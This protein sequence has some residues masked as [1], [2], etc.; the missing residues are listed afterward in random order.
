VL[1]NIGALIAM[2]TVQLARGEREPARAAATQ[3]EQ[4][5]RRRRDRAGLAEA[6]ELAVRAAPEPLAERDRLSETIALWRDL[7]NSLGV[8]KAELALAEL[9]VPAEA[10]QLAE[11]ALRR[12]Q[13]LGARRAASAATALI[14]SLARIQPS[15]IEFRTLG[16]FE[17]LRHGRPV[18][19]AEWRSRKARDALK[20]LIASRGRRLARDALMETLW[21]EEDPGRSA[22]RLSVALS[23]I[24]SVLDQDKENAAD[25]YL[26]TDRGSVW[27]ALDHLSV[28]LE[29]FHA[30]ARL[31]LELADE[32]QVDRALGALQAAEAAYHGDFLGEDPYEDWAVPAREAARGA[33]QQTLRTLADLALGRADPDIC[34]GYLR[35]LLEHDPYDEPVHLRLV[36]A[37][38]AAGHHGEARRAYQRYASRMEELNVEA[39]PL[40]DTVRQAEA[41]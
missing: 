36:A 34:A 21:P 9:S 18:P 15:A 30:N 25:H 26:R 39:A 4:L 40:P 32:G 3:A 38:S 20:V 16:G 28:D 22:P 31:G 17:V 24:R 14:E 19:V 2:G 12:F 41:S 10:R 13:Q 29:T 23:T 11:Q 37:L 35:R 5:A 33:Y 6:I 7:G 8:G 27:L 1:G